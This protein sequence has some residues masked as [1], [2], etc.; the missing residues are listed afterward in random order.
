MSSNNS[1]NNKPIQ[2][3]LNGLLSGFLA[4]KR[5]RAVTPFIKGRSR[6]CDIGCGIYNWSDVI[7]SKIHYVGLDIEDEIIKYN[8]EHFEHAFYVKDIEHD[9]LGEVGIDYDLVI[10]L[11]VL[12]HFNEPEVV[13]KKVKDILAVNGF[14]ALT[15]PHPCGNFILEVGA[16]IRLFSDDK[17]IHN[18]LLNK[19][20]INQ[21]AKVAGLKV[22]KYKRF[23]FGCN[24]LVLLSHENIPK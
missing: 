21:A 11:A 1:E 3:E 23:L 20:M 22:L 2:G 24:Q 18:R 4:R 17:H 13:L 9:D 16:K 12:E 8:Q 15:T 14:V 6:I 10:M 7:D 19:Q 5:I